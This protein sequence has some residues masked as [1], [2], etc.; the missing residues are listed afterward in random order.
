MP[1]SKTAVNLVDVLKR[2]QALLITQIKC[3]S[4]TLAAGSTIAVFSNSLV[5]LM[6]LSMTHETEQSRIFQ[7]GA[8][9]MRWADM[10]L[11]SS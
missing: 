1:F 6:S 7:S 9:G 11:K 8:L 10:I 2:P 3:F 5:M 4:L